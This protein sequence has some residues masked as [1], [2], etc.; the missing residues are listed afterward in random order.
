MLQTNLEKGS[1]AIILL[2]T[3]LLGVVT[4][5]AYYYG[6]STV[7]TSPPAPIS[8]T[9]SPAKPAAQIS[10]VNWEAVQHGR[11]MFK[12]PPDWWSKKYTDESG[13]IWYNVNPTV[14]AQPG[15][16]VPAFAIHYEKNTKVEDKKKELIDFWGLTETKEEAVTVGGKSGIKLEGT[17]QP[18]YLENKKMSWALFNAE[19]D[20]YYLVDTAASDN[21][22]ELFDQILSTFK[23]T[24]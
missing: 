11:L 17:T 18:G 15:D 13:N 20:L 6:R 12:I 22:K 2:I 14:L 9:P 21:H 24:Q 7:S 19:Y 16:A 4:F 23:F 5:G 3:L 10:T 8:S 1:T